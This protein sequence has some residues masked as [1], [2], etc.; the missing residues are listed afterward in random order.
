MFNLNRIT[1]IGHLGKDAETRFTTKRTAYSRFSIATN[2]SWKDKESGVD[3]DA[4]TDAQKSAITEI[5]QFYKAKSTELEIL[6]QAALRNA[7]S[8]EEIEQL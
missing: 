5:R 2:V 6:H 8:R 1:L 3:E 4:L 7:R